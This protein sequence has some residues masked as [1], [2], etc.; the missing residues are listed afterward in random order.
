MELELVGESELARV[1]LSAVEAASDAELSGCSL[2]VRNA[3]G[4]AISPDADGTYRLARGRTFT[5]V[6]SKLGY[7][8][9]KRE[10]SVGQ[11][12]AQS[13]TLSLEKAECAV[14]FRAVGKSASSTSTITDCALLE[15]ADMLTADFVS[16]LNTDR[17]NDTMRSVFVRG[18][19]FPLLKWEPRAHGVL[20]ETPRIAEMPQGNAGGAAYVVGTPASAL[21]ARDAEGAGIFTSFNQGAVF[22][23]SSTGE[24]LFGSLAGVRGANVDI[25]HCFYLAGTTTCENDASKCSAPRA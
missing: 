20:V 5:A 16:N 18:G 17:A 21:T 14:T 3:S 13:F 24:H 15:R 19:D 9:C 10:I 12:D 7:A 2:S 11:D 8:D 4:M 22:G 23:K 1:S 6:A 25:A